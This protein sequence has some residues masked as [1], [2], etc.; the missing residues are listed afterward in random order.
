MIAY[1]FTR[2]NPENHAFTVVKDPSHL[3]KYNDLRIIPS[4]TLKEM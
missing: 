2:V 1:L 4:L 3:D